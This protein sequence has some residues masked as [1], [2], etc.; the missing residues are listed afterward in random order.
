MSEA[1]P[2]QHRLLP[3][4]GHHGLV[5]DSGYRLTGRARTSATHLLSLA[6]NNV[7]HL[8]SFKILE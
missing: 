3:S 5:E 4:V 6:Q 2:R 1:P 8:A 7:L